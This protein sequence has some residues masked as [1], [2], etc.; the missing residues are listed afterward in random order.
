MKTVIKRQMSQ[1]VNVMKGQMFQNI[2]SQNKNRHKTNRNVYPNLTL[3]MVC[4]TG[5]RSTQPM[6][7]CA[8]C[9]NLT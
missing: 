9:P 6:D 5:Q 7:Q 3:D 8:M 2:T 1:K 4:Q